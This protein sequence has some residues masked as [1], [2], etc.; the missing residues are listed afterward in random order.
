MRRSKTDASL[1]A[2]ISLM[3]T[4]IRLRGTSKRPKQKWLAISGQPFS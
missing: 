1:N 2:F 3:A 4:V